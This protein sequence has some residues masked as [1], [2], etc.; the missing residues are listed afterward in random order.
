MANP[1]DGDEIIAPTQTAPVAQAA[2]PWEADE[3][4]AAADE[5]AL[6]IPEI[7]GGTIGAVPSEAELQALRDRKPAT[8]PASPARPSLFRMDSDFRDRS[9]VGVGDMLWASAKDMFGSREGAAEYLAGEAGGKVGKD[10]QGNPVVA[11]PDGTQYRLNDDGVDATDAANVAGNALAMFT[12]AGWAARIGQAR[13]LGLGGRS[14][15][16]AITAMTGDAALQAGFDG[17]RIDPVRTA[18]AGSGAAG[19]EAVGSGLTALAKRAVGAYNAASGRNAAQ[20]RNMLVEQ[21]VRATPESTNQ[22][23]RMI[24]E[25]E[26]GADPNALIGAQRYG[27]TYTQGQRALDSQR[28]FQ[29]LSQEEALRQSP[30]AGQLLRGAAER[31][32]LQLDSALSGITDKAGGFAGST[33]G[34]LVSGAADVLR[35][36]AR[37]LDDRISDAYLKA[38]EGARAAVNVEAVRG[39]PQMLRTSVADFAPNSTTTP[40]AARTLEQIEAATNALLAKGEQGESVA[41]VT[42]K[43]LETQRRI[44]NN[45]INATGTNRADKAAMVKIKREFDAWMDEAVDTALLS[46]DPKA[47]ATMKEARALRAEYGRRFEGGAESDRFISGLLDGSRTPEELVNIALGA[48]QVSKSGGARFIERLRVASGNDPAVI[49]NLR[50]AHLMRLTRGNNG[51]PLQMGQIV[52]NVRTT[53]YNN[54]SVIKALY[55]KAEWNELRLLAASLEPLVA[56]GDFART[57]GTAERMAR[58]MF[59]KMGG[60]LPIVGEAIKGVGEVR[61]YLQAQRALNQ[62]LRLPGGAGPVAPALG[63]S[64]SGEITR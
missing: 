35:G 55:S 20:A 49:G 39:L 16:Q 47:L 21:G 2:A 36:Q 37:E 15:L 19:G 63:A 13:R 51:E 1:W 50:A 48:S 27:F 24:P 14:A 5:P 4:V 29:L 38:G 30:A 34:E 6:E 9:G 43:A 53:E 62:P 3:I 25:M 60:G 58:M 12:P 8:A 31:N 56:K 23:A 22:L 40:I 32:A 42:L 59:T 17:G 54:A 41:G 33:P 26:A 10:A 57:S 46:G 52:R 18:A 45:N 11:L 28:K 61:G 64:T 7:T 44:L